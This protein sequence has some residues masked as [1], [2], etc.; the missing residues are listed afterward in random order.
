VV[1]Q[2]TSGG[3]APTLDRSIALARIAPGVDGQC[4]V[5]IRGKSVPARI[6]RPPFVRNGAARIDL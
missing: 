4:A 6:V 5:E 1:G 2:V 3:F